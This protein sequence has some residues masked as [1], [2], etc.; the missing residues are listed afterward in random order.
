MK[1]NTL[2]RYIRFFE[3]LA[4]DAIDQIDDLFSPDAFFSDP[5][6]RVRG[7]DAIKRIFQHLLDNHP[8]TR[9]RVDENLGQGNTFF[10][11]WC[12]WPDSGGDL[13][14]EGASRVVFNPA[15]EVIEHRDYWDSASQLYAQLPL[16]GPPTRWL[17]RRSCAEPAD[18]VSD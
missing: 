6:N 18:Q 5:F 1:P 14:I 2:P 3:T 15:G 10:L 7:R 13:C 17:L 9:F 12:F 8:A 4:P 16:I 11:V